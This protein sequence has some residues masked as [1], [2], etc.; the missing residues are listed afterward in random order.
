MRNE[1]ASRIRDLLDVPPRP[2]PWAE[3]DN[4]PGQEPAFSK[5]MLLEHLS[6]SHD[7]ASRRHTTIDAH[8]DWIHQNVLRE[9]TGSILDL[10][11]GPGFYTSRLARLGHRCMGSTTPRR[12]SRTRGRKAESEDLARRYLHG[13]LRA[14]EFGSGH[15]LA[16]LIFWEFNVFSPGHVRQILGRRTVRSPRAGSSCSNHIRLRRCRSS[17]RARPRRGSSPEGSS[18][19]RPTSTL[20]ES[21]WDPDTAT[22]TRATSLSIAVAQRCRTSP[23]RCRPTPKWRTKRSWRRRVSRTFASFPRSRGRRR[24]SKRGCSRLGPSVAPAT[25]ESIRPDRP[26]GARLIR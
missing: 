16:L 13:D 17:G 9:Q 21:F 23:R 6:Q 12:R 7:L 3:G 19:T 2:A 25:E 15:D 4:I 24:R 8:V 1:D 18:R 22:A 11:C 10:G 5:R 20:E 14:A 26:R